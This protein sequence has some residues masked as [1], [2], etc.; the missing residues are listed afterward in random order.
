MVSNYLREKRE[1]AGLTQL[2][3]SRRLG[4][5]SSQYISNIERG[6]SGIPLGKLTPIAAALKVKEADLLNEIKKEK[7]ITFKGFPKIKRQSNN[8]V[9]SKFI[10]LYKNC[11]LMK[12]NSLNKVLINLNDKIRRRG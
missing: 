7:G 5:R 10:N 11:D 9:L 6:L 8:T 12:R 1:K 3:L 4:Y 2:T